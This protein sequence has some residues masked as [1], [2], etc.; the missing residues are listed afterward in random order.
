MFEG[1]SQEAVDFLWGIT[2]HNERSWFLA[3]KEEYSTLLDAPLKAL[4]HEVFDALEPDLP[5]RSMHLHVCRI[6]R[7]ARRLHG[8]GP[9]KEHL[10]F[11]IERPHERF[12]GVPCLYFE[13]A[14]NYF[15]Y[16]CGYWNAGASTMAKLRHRIDT[17][18]APLEKITRKLR[19]SRFT[20]GG[21]E[22]KRPK[23]D[24]GTLLNP[25]YN[26]K[27]ILISYEDDPDGVLFTPQLKDEL[28]D[29]FRLLMPAFDY[30][31]SLSADPV[32]ET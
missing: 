14:P 16:G 28:V 27:N 18:P 29:G 23:G 11:Q 32:P 17:S 1:F 19:R 2:L 22:Y 6:Y 12:E 25:W 3:H 20:L 24:A 4:G 15:S 7:D 26:R 13:I 5:P 9:Y 10:W 31:D 8:R 21:E 30:L